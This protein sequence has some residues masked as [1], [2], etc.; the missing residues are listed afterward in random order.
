M[1]DNLYR[2]LYNNIKSEILA[3]LTD[4]NGQNDLTGLCPTDLIGLRPSEN[5]KTTQQNTW[6]EDPID[7]ED[8]NEDKNEDDE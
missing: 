5:N 3:S 6:I 4:Q 8:N 7:N 2:Q 1:Y